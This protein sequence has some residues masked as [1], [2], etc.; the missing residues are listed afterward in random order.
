VAEL[1]KT[2]FLVVADR[3]G[4]VVAFDRKGKVRWRHFSGSEV[5]GPIANS[6]KT[7]FVPTGDGRQGFLVALNLSNG[8]PRWKHGFQSS[9]SGPA[10][11]TND[12]VFATSADGRVYAL[13]A[14]SGRKLW[15]EKVSS[16]IEGGLTVAGNTLLVRAGNAESNPGPELVAYRLG[17]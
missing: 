11:A 6:G 17:G 9:L 4:S 3:S 16:T 7:V 12:V 5:V 1:G 2:K 13:S 15:S 14:K 10:L 8:A